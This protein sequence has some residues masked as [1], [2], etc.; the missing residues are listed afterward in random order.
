MTTTRSHSFLVPS[1]TPISTQQTLD[2]LHTLRHGDEW[3]IN[4]IAEHRALTTDQLVA[5]RLRSRPRHGGQTTQAPRPARMPPPLRPRIHRP[6]IP[7]HHTLVHRT[8]RHGHHHHRRQ[9]RQRRPGAPGQGTYRRDP[10]LPHLLDVNQFFV[11][12]AVYARTNPSTTNLR[13]WWSP[14]TCHRIAASPRHKMWHGEYLHDDRRVG[15]WLE[16]DDGTARPATLAAHIHH[17]HAIAARTEEPAVLFHCTDGER[18]AA[19]RQRLSRLAEDLILKCL[20]F[21]DRY[22]DDRLAW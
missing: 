4:M 3:A 7:R 17:Y 9:T 2:H 16:P 1:T 15:F 8:V 20:I 6:R 11:A 5:P 13:T 18:E 14:F 21:L 10:H 12:L 19:L 22:R